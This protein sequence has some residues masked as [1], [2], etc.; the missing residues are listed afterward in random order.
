VTFKT[1]SFYPQINAGISLAGY[2]SPTPI[3]LQAIPIV[4]DGKDLFGLAQTGTGKT[5]AFV[6]P[7]LQRLMTGPRGKPRALILSPTR[8]LAEQIHQT[9]RQLGSR[10]G[11][12]SETIYGGVSALPQ[13]R[14]LR[15]GVDIVVACPGRLLD[16]YDQKVINL[17]SIEVLVLDE[18]DRM[19]DMGFLPSIRRIISVL[20]G[21]RQ[22]LLF[23]ATMPKEI[24]VLASEM[25]VNPQTV[26]IG[27]TQPLESISHSIYPVE[28]D[29]KLEM[30]LDLIHASGNGQVLVFTR[31]KHRARKVAAQLIKAGHKATSLQGNLSQGQRQAAMDSFRSGR[32]RIMVAT[33][34]AARGIDISQVS[35]V[36]NFDLPDTAEAYTH[37]TGRTG[38]MQRLG[39]ALSLVTQEDLPMV[40]TIER[41]MGRPLK[42]VKPAGPKRI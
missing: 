41:L 27:I 42:L 18:A 6:L 2:S 22:T 30:L 15:S 14:S 1:F 38:R 5:A 32:A 12:R 3:Q 10:T 19:F 36:I 28:S 11:L 13:I 24:R 33:D 16:L 21:Q 31:T 40:R 9:I 34:I 39:E 7:L 23:S 17:R 4:L 29:R 25:L 35:H 37:R 8:E 20:P 26:D